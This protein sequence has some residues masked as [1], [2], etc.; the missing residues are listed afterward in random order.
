MIKR[1][2]F[3]LTFL[4]PFIGSTQELPNTFII[5]EDAISIGTDF[6]IETGSDVGTIEQ[7]VI[8]LGSN[9]TLEMDGTLVAESRQHIISFGSKI[10]ILDGDG[11]KIG[12]IEERIF[13]GFFGILSNYFIYNNNGKVIAK[14]TKHDLM[15]TEFIIRDMNDKPIAKISRPMFELVSDTWTVK[16]L[17]TS[18][19]KRLIVFIPAYKTHR[20]NEK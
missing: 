13:G 8:S 16:F 10:S 15:A 14:S 4:I 19:D 12:M 11:Y 5:E 1:L 17:N 2:L 18:F 9:F 6:T 7:E 20:D 3:L